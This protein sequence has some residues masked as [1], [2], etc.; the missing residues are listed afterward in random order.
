MSKNLVTTGDQFAEKGSPAW[1]DW[2]RSRLRNAVKDTN[3]EARRIA[4]VIIDMH[5]GDAVAWHLMTTTSGKRFRTFEEFVT[6]TPPDGLGLDYPKF[7]GMATSDPSFMNVR[8][9]DRM[10]VAPDGRRDNKRG[11]KDDSRPG[12]E[13]QSIPRQISRL[14]AIDRAPALV[15]DL[16]DAGLIDAK[17]AEQMGPDEKAPADRKARARRAYEAV[18]A[19][20]RNGDDAAYRR[21]VNAAAREALGVRKPARSREAVAKDLAQLGEEDFLWAVKEAKRLRKEQS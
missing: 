17:L 21:S 14:R 3:F 12:G 16:Y 8:K 18:Q 20:R 2:Q 4:Q 13:N 7:K 9:Y 1:A 6:A 15:H 19:V 11:G 5:H 10:T